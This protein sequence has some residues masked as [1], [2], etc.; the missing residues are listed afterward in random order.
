MSVVAN[1]YGQI[2]YEGYYKAC[3]GK[4]L[5]SGAALPEWS[6]Q[7]EAIQT[8]WC[9]GAVAVLEAAQAAVDA[10]NAA[11]LKTEGDA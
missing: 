1:S 10:R 3:G 6:A 7:S 11:A 9:A 5:I 2:A 4:S 8:A